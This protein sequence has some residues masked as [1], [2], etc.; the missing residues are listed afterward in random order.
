MRRLLNVS[1]I[2]PYA[3]VASDR[4]VTSYGIT[5]H[6]Y[7]LSSTAAMACALGYDETVDV[8]SITTEASGSM[9]YSIDLGEILLH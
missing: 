7:C 3:R 8:R 4:S 5:L 6:P 2:D 9:K 1:N